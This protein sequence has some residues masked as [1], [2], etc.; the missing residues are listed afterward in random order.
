MKVMVVCGSCY[1]L[2]LYDRERGGCCKMRMDLAMP[3]CFARRC[4]YFIGVIQPDGIEMTETVSCKAFPKGVPN[5]IAYGNNLHLTVV[6]G[7]K[8]DY[9]FEER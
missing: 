6:N 7:Q 8:G 3:V 1:G 2:N 4:K 5:D 9:V